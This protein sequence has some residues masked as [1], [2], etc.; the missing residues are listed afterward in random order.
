MENF[1]TVKKRMV[2]TATN[3][4]AMLQDIPKILAT[5]KTPTK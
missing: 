3:Y 4:Q 1:Q 5:K 2:L